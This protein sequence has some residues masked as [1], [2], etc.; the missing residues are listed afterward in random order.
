MD[1][2]G[3]FAGADADVGEAD[4][5]G[6]AFSALGA[7]AA[8]GFLTAFLTGAGLAGGAGF[9]I[10]GVGSTFFGNLAWFDGHAFQHVQGN[11]RLLFGGGVSHFNSDQD[12][13]HRLVWRDR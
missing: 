6:S 11:Q 12:F 10:T 5:A 13:S 1:L 2:S 4:A 3:A 9:S 7:A 8:T